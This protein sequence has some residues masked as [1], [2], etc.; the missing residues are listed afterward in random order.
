MYGNPAVPAKGFLMATNCN[1]SSIARRC[2]GRPAG[3]TVSRAKP[4]VVGKPQRN[5]LFITNLAFDITFVLIRGEQHVTLICVWDWID[6]KK[7]EI[8]HRQRI[9]P[10]AEKNNTRT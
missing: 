8:V 1:S 7:C 4:V 9:D 10:L 3:G 2:C 5:L 6:A